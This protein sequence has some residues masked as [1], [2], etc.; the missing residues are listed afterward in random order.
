MFSFPKK[1]W[2]IGLF[3]GII[4]LRVLYYWR[5][6]GFSIDRISNSFP[7]TYQL[8]S[9]TT[10]QLQAL[11]SICKEPFYYLGKGSQAY[12][13]ESQDGQYVLKLFKCY[14]LKPIPW[15]EK[16]ELPGFVGDYVQ[17]HLKRRYNKTKLSL[18]SYRIAH[19]VIPEECGL[20]FLQIV[21]SQNFQQKATFTDK[22]GRTFTIDLEN[23]GFMIQRKVDLIFPTLRKFIQAGNLEQAKELM[24]SIVQLI[25]TRSQKGVLDQDPD[26][27]KNCGCVAT[28][29]QFIDVG[30][31]H[32]SERAKLPETYAFDARKITRKLKNF[33]E[34]EAPALLDSLEQDLQ[35]LEQKTTG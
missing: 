28:K 25:V 20:L 3:V 5:S 32:M 23:Y 15:L 35:A 11:H 12:A 31:F 16:L 26:I 7:T 29:A 30:S 6:D 17:Q 9:P 1:K 19:D 18:E 21:P 4:A 8:S 2:V 34:E 14:H 33:L 13:F 10:E 27:H 22:I 24:H